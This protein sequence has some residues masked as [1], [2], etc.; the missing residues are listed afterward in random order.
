M[1][2]II[3]T[4]VRSILKRILYGRKTKDNVDEKYV[5]QEIGSVF[6]SIYKDNEWA[7]GAESKYKKDGTDFYS[8]SGSYNEAAQKYISFIRHYIKENNIKSITDFGCG[9]FNIGKQICDNNPDLIY[10]GVDIVPELIEHNSKTHGNEKIRFHCINTLKNSVPTADLLLVRQV[11][12]HL[13]NADIQRVIDN[14]FSKFKD[15]LITEHQ[16]KKPYL[17][18]VNIDKASGPN[19]R[20]GFGSG[21]YLNKSPFH[22]QWKL[23]FSA[24]DNDN[25]RCEINTYK[26]I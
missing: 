2:R 5:G 14:S 25:E 24:D 9:D 11:L 20:L 10:N 1:K 6:S 23:I 7:K 21:V 16:V 15:V 17:V 12:Q 8:G 4:S 18:K 13:S 3:P 22:L 26:I 19:T